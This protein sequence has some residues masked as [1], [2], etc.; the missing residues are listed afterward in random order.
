[1]KELHQG[2]AQLLGECL[3]EQVWATNYSE[4]SEPPHHPETGA[5][6]TRIALLESMAE[7]CKLAAEFSF[8]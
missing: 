6:I 8:T 3:R 4:K 1:M 5:M 7:P 2:H